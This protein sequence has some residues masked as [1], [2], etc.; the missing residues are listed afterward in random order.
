MLLTL[1][2]EIRKQM[3]IV[4]S[5]DRISYEVIDGKTL[6]I[7]KNE[8]N[9]T[10]YKLSHAGQVTIP[11]GI[12]RQLDL[13]NYESIKITKIEDGWA[14]ASV[15]KRD[16]KPNFN[17]LINP[18]HEKLKYPEKPANFQVDFTNISENRFWGINRNAIKYCAGIKDQT[19]NFKQRYYEYAGDL[20]AATEYVK[21]LNVG[22]ELI[23]LYP[24]N[25][26]PSVK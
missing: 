21:N 18:N 17:T 11:L 8:E 14:L 16:I 6:K 24:V 20:I 5:E 7:R 9:V 26:I 19:D 23:Y 25:N 22:Q 15:V 10:T 4:T 13:S 3:S 2:K 12:L 1:N